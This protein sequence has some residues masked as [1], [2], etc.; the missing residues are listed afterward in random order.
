MIYGHTSL[1]EDEFYNYTKPEEMNNIEDL[2]NI[3]DDAIEGGQEDRKQADK[4][5]AKQQ[6]DALD[7]LA[8]ITSGRE[9]IEELDLI[10]LENDQKK[11]LQ[12]RMELELNLAI[13]AVNSLSEILKTTKYTDFVSGL[14][15]YNRSAADMLRFIKEDLS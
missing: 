6:R 2:H 8:V 12:K 9:E 5:L 4:F 3:I 1:V 14:D 10:K 13:D 7:L 15:S 11:V